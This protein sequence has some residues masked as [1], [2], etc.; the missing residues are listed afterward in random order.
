[1]NCHLS[2]M[3]LTPTRSSA[4]SA[5]K[6]HHPLPARP[7]DIASST[8]VPEYSRARCTQ[9][10]PA[11]TPVASQQAT[12]HREP[13]HRKRRRSSNLDVDDS[14]RSK[15]VPPAAF[16]RQL[17]RVP[18]PSASKPNEA[19]LRQ[20]IGD[21][22]RRVAAL[23]C[24]E[25]LLHK[26]GREQSVLWAKDHPE[27]YTHLIDKFLKL[28]DTESTGADDP[29]E[30]SDDAA[31]LYEHA[32]YEQERP[33]VADTG[34][35]QELVFHLDLDEIDLDVRLGHR[36]TVD[37]NQAK[38]SRF[39]RYLARHPAH[40]DA[41]ISV[42][43]VPAPTGD[44][45]IVCAWPISKFGNPFQPGWN[46]EHID[47]RRFLRDSTGYIDPLSDLFKTL[48][49]E[50]SSLDFAHRSN[51]QRQ[52]VSTALHLQYPLRQTVR[53]PDVLELCRTNASRLSA[54]IRRRFGAEP[55]KQAVYSE[56]HL[57][58][59]AYWMHLHRCAPSTKA[60]DRI[61]RK[62]WLR[63]LSSFLLTWLPKHSE[64]IPEPADEPFP[65][66][67]EPFEGPVL[68]NDDKTMHAIW[69]HLLR[70]GLGTFT[71]LGP[72]RDIAERELEAEEWSQVL[73]AEA[74]ALGMSQSVA[75][76][77]TAERA[78]W[79]PILQPADARIRVKLSDAQVAKLVA[80]QTASEREHP[81][82]KF[83]DAWSVI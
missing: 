42:L 37:T 29:G 49:G 48:A 10:N 25:H 31:A 7:P 27:E 14:N 51:A 62:T 82:E 18:S 46:W 28:D 72:V 61:A 81:E 12:S 71:V 70:C 47:P 67:P 52:V 35:T 59:L 63:T 74:K 16:L 41:A 65:A 60:K 17:P 76:Q 2:P 11:H 21:L 57:L 80:K 69:V 53:E 19:E 75:R 1:M 24:E 55:S 9:P 58:D 56:F 38:A 83:S 50:A 54:G 5:P 77:Y 13:S 45:H 30:L 73:R 4:S 8:S 79:F 22:K 3:D 68:E 23:R 44:H 36:A 6:L 43:R 64:T 33:T 15:R 20:Y 66:G 39:M 78:K 26:Y 32:P 40:W 34:N